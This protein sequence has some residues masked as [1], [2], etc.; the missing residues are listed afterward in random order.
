M[1]RLIV[2]RNGREDSGIAEEL[3]ESES[4]A[5]ELPQIACFRSKD[6]RVFV[7]QLGT[8]VGVD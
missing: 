2:R 7:A 1:F 3:M 6:A 5:M 8:K 4:T